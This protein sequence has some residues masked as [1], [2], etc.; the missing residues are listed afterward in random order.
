MATQPY[1]ARPTTLQDLLAL[2]MNA[3][4]SPTAPPGPPQASY[5]DTGDMLTPEQ[6][7][8]L[9]DTLLNPQPAAP[10]PEDQQP[11]WGKKVAGSFADAFNNIATIYA[12][13]PNLR[14]NYFNEYMNQ[15]E[16]QNAQ[17]RRQ[18]EI[19]RDRNA[20]QSQR[21]AE[22]L[23]SADERAQMKR[24]ELI[25][26]KELQANALAAQKDAL[27]ARQEAAANTI[28]LQQAEI[29]SREKIAK[30]ETDARLRSDSLQADLHKLKVTGE[31]DKDQHKEYAEMRQRIVAAKPVIEK[32]IVDGQTTPEQAVQEW[33]DMLDASDLTGKYRDAANAMW[34]DKIGTMLMRHAPA[35]GP[36]PAPYG[37]EGVND[38][39]QP[40]AV[41]TVPVP[42]GT[43]RFQ[44]R[45]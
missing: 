15:I 24:D 36:S 4:G 18:A 21:K 10:M 40:G 33:N 2:N 20:A 41:P 39:R 23:L 7:S 8:K 32:S 1:N 30:M 13:G 43:S 44:Y 31:A 16:R 22:F 5:V 25:G 26:R 29:L 17:Q 9:V 45:P 27:Q 38:P 12:G 28:A 6:R 11:S 14:S 37:Y 34:Q 3:G 19:D 42:V 35:Q